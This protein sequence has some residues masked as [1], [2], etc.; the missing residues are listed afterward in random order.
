MRGAA[1][2]A[3]SR[4]TG[5]FHVEQGCH[6]AVIIRKGA[7]VTGSAS[8]SRASYPGDKLEKLS[9]L[10]EKGEGNE[11]RREKSHRKSGNGS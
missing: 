8:F 4:R 3:R 2:S 10:A 9:L 6:L 7:V 1:A 11:S 5:D